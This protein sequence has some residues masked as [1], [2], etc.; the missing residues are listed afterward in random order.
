MHAILTL[1]LVT[2]VGGDFLLK[3]GDPAPTFSMRALSREMWS[4]DEHVGADPKVQKKA[5][6]MAFFATWCVPCKAEIPILKDLEKRWSPKGV[7]L[8][9]LG[10]SQGAKD[11]EPFA[12]EFSIP[13]PVI[14]DQFGLLGRR[15]GAAQLP[16]LVIVDA[17]GRIAFQHRGIVPNLAQLLDGELGRITGESTTGAPILAA[18]PR[19]SKTLKLGRVPA[20]SQSAG[21]WQPLAAFL[22][23]SAGANVEVS[24]EEGYAAFEAALKKGKYEIANAGPLLCDQLRATYEPIARIERQGQPTYQGL[25]F[26][27]RDGAPASLGE[28]RG[29]RVGL[30]AEGSTS[31]GL[32]QLLALIDAG[33]VPG[34]DVTVTYLGD[35]DAV[36]RAV[37]S[38]KVDAGGCYEDCRDAVWG[39]EGKK[40]GATRVLG[41]TP[42]IPGDFIIVRKDLDI[43]TKQQLQRGLLALNDQSSILAQISQGETAVTAITPASMADLAAIKEAV[44]RVHRATKP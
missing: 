21:R 20:S 14:P 32:Y 17:D 35:H 13:W 43:T 44:S 29:K 28:L 1:A 34:K 6:V 4:L 27:L 12:K 5:M 30:V 22:G 24:T 31:G 11:L 16:H 37:Q 33:L 2:A 15:Y 10:F 7:G 36:A 19:F 41:Y 42:P 9:Y 23:E 25:L 18:A 39:D 26:A 3:T 8:I 40:N 38:G